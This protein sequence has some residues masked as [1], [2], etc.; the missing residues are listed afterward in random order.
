MNILIG[1]L[2]GI[3]SGFGLGGGTLLMLWLTNVAGLEQQA[4]Q[5][6]NLLYF[7]PCAAGSIFFHAKNKLIDWKTT[8]PAVIAGICA[9]VPFTFL[10]QRMDSGLLR[11]IFGA[12][13]VI[14]GLRE[15]FRKASVPNKS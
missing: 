10:A 1:A 2:T 4:A 12:G 3:L 13:V 15:L 9:A 11:K 6:V 8:V 14:V 7:L 5:G